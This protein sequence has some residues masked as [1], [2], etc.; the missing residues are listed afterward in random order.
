MT[1]THNAE[2]TCLEWKVKCNTKRDTATYKIQTQPFRSCRLDMVKN[3]WW[4]LTG[5]RG[6]MK[7]KRK[8]TPSEWLRWELTR[9]PHFIQPRERGQVEW[10]EREEGIRLCD[11]QVMGLK[12]RPW[13]S[14]GPIRHKQPGRTQA[15]HWMSSSYWQ[16]DKYDEN[17]KQQWHGR[18]RSTEIVSLPDT[19]MSSLCP[20]WKYFKCATNEN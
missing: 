11:H 6:D 16:S 2:Q 20:S 17:P 15:C 3:R 4:I 19:L 14:N 5:F 7:E 18:V 13:N 1:R 10:R 8:E 9:E 12:R